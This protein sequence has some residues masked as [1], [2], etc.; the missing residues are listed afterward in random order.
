MVNWKQRGAKV[1]ASF[2]TGYGGGFAALLPT[3]AVGIQIELEWI[4]LL[5]TLSGLV[6]SFPQLGKIFNEYAG[7]KND[8]I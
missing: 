5:P 7:M 8:G 3:P 6:V 2:F 1:L 4:F